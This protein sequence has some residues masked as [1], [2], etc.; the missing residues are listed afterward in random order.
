MLI[1]HFD[2]HVQRRLVH[3]EGWFIGQV[4]K[5]IKSID[6]DPFVNFLTRH[7]DQSIAFDHG[8]GAFSASVS[9]SSAKLVQRE[10]VTP[11][12]NSV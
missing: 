9:D 2:V 12:N 10:S 5:R 1:L 3:R 11:S 6:V 7:A 4:M 8:M